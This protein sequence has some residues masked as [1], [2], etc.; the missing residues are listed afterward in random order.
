MAERLRSVVIS[1]CICIGCLVLTVGC[2]GPTPTPV[3][4]ETAGP[5]RFEHL[6]I[7]VQRPREMANWYCEI[8]G[9]KIVREQRIEGAILLSDAD[10][11][12]TMK[13][14]AGAKQSGPTYATLAHKAT[15]VAFSAENLN[16][17]REKLISAGARPVGQIVQTSEGHLSMNFRD[18]W[19]NPI[20]FGRHAFPIR[21]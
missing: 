17:L 8:L 9:F 11:T 10:G 7:K 2:T 12:L 5:V 21:K 4:G 13:L 14:Y 1:G 15:H 3:E 19:G 6:A 20:Q 18:P 16:V